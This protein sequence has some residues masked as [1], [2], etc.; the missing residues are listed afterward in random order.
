MKRIPIAVAK[1]IAKDYGYDQILIYGRKVG[2]NPEPH[3]E[4]I[5]TYGVTKEHCSVMA[6]ISQHLQKVIGWKPETTKGDLK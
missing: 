3:G 1:K 5:T 2:K 4:H 6:R